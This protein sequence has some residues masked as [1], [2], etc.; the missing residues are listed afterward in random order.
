M[1]YKVNIFIEKDEAGYYVHA[2]DLPGCHSQGQTFEEALANIKE[3]I[4][5]YVETVPKEELIT[6]LSKEIFST[7]VEI[8]VA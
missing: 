5:L 4:D 2:P 3:A 1:N 8:K 7:S 6:M